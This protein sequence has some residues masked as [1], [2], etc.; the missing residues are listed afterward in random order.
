MLG[1]EK[2]ESLKTALPVAN[3]AVERVG[4]KG[5]KE[6]VMCLPRSMQAP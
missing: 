3:F 1:Y 2:M 4:S 5:L 6:D